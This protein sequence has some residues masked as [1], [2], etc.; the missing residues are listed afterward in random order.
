SLE[1]RYRQAFRSGRIEVAGT[2]A[3][4]RIRPDETR[5]QITASGVFMLP[6]DYLLTFRAEAVSD[7]A[8]LLD[9]DISSKD[10]L[11]SQIE[12]M[13]ARRDEYISA[14]LVHF[15]SIREGD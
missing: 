8:Y 6:R 5:G 2:V 1:L 12:V 3:R 11:D 13:R 4:D 9:Y 7:P 14:R 15:N 10:R